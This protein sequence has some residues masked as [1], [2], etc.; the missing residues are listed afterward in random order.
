MKIVAMILLYK[1]RIFFICG[2]IN[3][4]KSRNQ[5]LKRENDE[6]TKRINRSE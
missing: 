6:L 5:L 2:R 1:L 4:I 3:A